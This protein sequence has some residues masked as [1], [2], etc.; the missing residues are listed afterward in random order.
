MYYFDYNCSKV[1]NSKAL[2][3][4]DSNLTKGALFYKKA[5]FHLDAHTHQKSPS[6]S[7]GKLYSGLGVDKSFPYY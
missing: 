6:F 3:C 5:S 2:I 7:P 4:V 1:T